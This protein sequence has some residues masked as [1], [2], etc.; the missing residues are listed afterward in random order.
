M[1]INKT[2]RAE[3][4]LQ[5]LPS[6]ALQPSQIDFLHHPAEF[7]QQIIQL[8]REAKTRIYITA[9]YWQN[10]EA[11]QEILNE[12]FAA[13]SR[14][15]EL[16]VKIFVDWHRTQ[17]NLLGAEKS[18]TNADWYCEQR[19]IHQYGEH[20]HLFFGVPVN[21]REVFGV[22]HIKGFIFDDTLLYSGAS[23]NNVYLQQNEKYRYDRYHKITHSALA[24]SMVNFLQQYLLSNQAVL[25]L[26]NAERPKTKEIRQHIRAF[27]KG[28]ATD[29]QYKFTSEENS[30]L[31]ITP[32]FGLGGGANLLNRTI[33][34]LFQIVQE[35]LVICTPY[36]NFPRP[37]QQKI[38]R[39]L[40][41][42]KHIEII[43]GDKTAND[44]YIPPSQPFKMAGALPYLYE[45]NLRRFSQ[46][47]EAQITQ[48][49][50]VIRTWKDGENSY[51]LKGV[52]VDNNHILLTGNN[53]NPR[54]WR[55]DAENG[56][57]IQDPNQQLA[58]Q[59]EQELATIRQHTTQ[60]K[61]YSEL[62]ELAQYPEPVQKLLKK[63]ARIKADKLVKMIL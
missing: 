8:I 20:A 35:K 5:A 3:E 14:N 1:L 43:V 45:S 2:K 57:L 47:F 62:E 11:G 36:F 33:E 37:L 4:N 58:S 17:R 60:L 7:K 54:A 34:D 53:L 49:Q 18:A 56:L 30:G 55:L 32:L 38:R 22:L 12:V 9:L 15:P 42:G 46:K 63:F 31:K 21:T 51:H 19:A 29:G 59:V 40:Q 25:P 10:D 24:D 6:L 26:D 41:K 23:I 27:R 48:G 16:E 52:W 50:L 44:F 61:H 28:L 13:K 39:L